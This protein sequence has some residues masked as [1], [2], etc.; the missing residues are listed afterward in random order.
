MDISERKRGDRQKLARLI[1]GESNAMQRDRLRSV[2]R[3][4]QGRQTLEVS[5]SVGRSR[6]FVQRWAYAYRDGGIEAVQGRTLTAVWAIKGS[7]PTVVRQNGR[8]SIWVFTAVEPATGWLLA[9]PFRDVNT[10]TMQAFLD[11]AAS[12]L[13]CREHAVMILDGAGWH[14][15]HKLRWPRRITPLF[16]SPYSPELNPVERLW[17]R[18]REHH[19]SNRTYADEQALV[20]EAV[21][22]HRTLRRKDVRSIC[23]TRWITP[24]D[25]VAV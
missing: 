23:R 19:W 14:R 16:L 7:R 2:L 1:A 10:A 11:A 24:E 8:K 3:V 13:H 17:P 5:A 22:S 20:E 9:M 21:R 12:K 4:L 6:A 18:L 25:Q 15:A